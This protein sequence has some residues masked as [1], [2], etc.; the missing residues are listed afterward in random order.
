M[1]GQLVAEA[2]TLQNTQQTQGEKIPCPQRD[3]NP[4]SQKSMGR[5]PTPET[6]R[7]PGSKAIIRDKFAVI[8]VEVEMLAVVFCYA[9][10]NLYSV[11]PSVIR[12]E[13]MTYIAVIRQ[14]QRQL[15]YFY[16]R[17]SVLC[18]MFRQIWPPSGDKHYVRNTWGGGIINI[19]Y[20]KQK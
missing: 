15:Y 13:V 11:Q 7:P 9:R 18:G 17:F 16:E 5:R 14:P 6:A 19:R 3:L 4:R 1:S 12:H 10:V 8:I 20:S 2:A